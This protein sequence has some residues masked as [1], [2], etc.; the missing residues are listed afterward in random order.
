MIQNLSDVLAFGKPVI[1]NRYGSQSISLCFYEFIARNTQVYNTK[2]LMSDVILLYNCGLIIAMFLCKVGLSKNTACCRAWTK[3][4]DR[5]WAWSWKCS[6]FN[7]LRCGHFCL[8]WCSWI[9]LTSLM[10]AHLTWTVCS[11][12]NVVYSGTSSFSYTK[13]P[14]MAS[15]CIEVV[16]NGKHVFFMGLATPQK[17][18]L[19]CVYR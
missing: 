19:K 13:A 14:L 8:K 5:E 6:L 1:R 9:A 10:V 11:L 15:F 12:T 4:D 3:K 17:S 16:C 7:F 2:T 18:V